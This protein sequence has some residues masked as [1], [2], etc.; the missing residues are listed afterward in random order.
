M[1]EQTQRQQ[2]NRRWKHKWWREDPD[3]FK[4]KK[5]KKTAQLRP[6]R[7]PT[8]DLT[9]SGRRLRQR[10]TTVPAP[11]DTR[12]TGR[13]SERRRRPPRRQLARMA[14]S[15]ALQKSNTRR[16]RATRCCS[17]CWVLV[18][19]TSR[20]RIDTTRCGRS[21]SRAEGTSNNQNTGSSCEKNTF[22]KFRAGEGTE[23]KDR[24]GIRVST[25]RTLSRTAGHIKY[26]TKLPK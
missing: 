15:H 25:G 9:S 19:S 2:Q 4:K 1:S 10:T 12:A 26:G 16:N 7:Q 20:P 3:F 5:K 11:F 8:P 21:P 23:P 17:S 24:E 14:L 22:R 13:S 18:F 6:P